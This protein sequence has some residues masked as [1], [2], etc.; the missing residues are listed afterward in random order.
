MPS[1]NARVM[2]REF[3][4]TGI[5]FFAAKRPRCASAPRFWW[6]VS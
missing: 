4:G 3:G 1:G 5:P 2:Q 6:V